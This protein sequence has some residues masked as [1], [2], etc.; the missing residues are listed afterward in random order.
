MQASPGYPRDFFNRLLVDRPDFLQQIMARVLKVSLSLLD[1]LEEKG[2]LGWGQNLI[3]C[4]GAH[5]DG[6]PAPGSDP[7]RPRARG[8][9]TYGMAQIFS[10]VSPAMHKEFWLDYAVHWFGRFGLGYYGCCEPLN[11]KIDIIRAVPNVRKIS[12][13]PFADVVVGAERIGG[14]YV[15]SRKPPPSLLAGDDWDPEAVEKDLAF[16]LEHCAR[17][18][19]PVELVLKHISTVRYEPRR[20]WEWAD[21]ARRLVGVSA[22]A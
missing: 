1:Q 3:H 14:D 10:S 4:T 13:S 16:T 11:E 20:L 17:N 5:A 12:M 21:I 6:L 19:C 9:W 7:A 15:F 22:S 8:L 2:L 18:G